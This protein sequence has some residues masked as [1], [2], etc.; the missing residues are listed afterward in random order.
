MVCF[1]NVT[2]SRDL[3]VHLPGVIKLYYLVADTL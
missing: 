3:P 2:V 1:Y